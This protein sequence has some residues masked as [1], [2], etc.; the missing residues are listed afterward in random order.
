MTRPWI[1]EK[2]ILCIT[3]TIPKLYGDRHFFQDL[4]FF[5]WIHS[6][7]MLVSY[8]N[9]SKIN[10]KKGKYMCLLLEAA[11]A[12]NEYRTPGRVEHPNG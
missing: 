10:K 3:G 1:L 5:I 6:I 11:M 8:F 9:N 2:K 12:I 7:Y 4:M